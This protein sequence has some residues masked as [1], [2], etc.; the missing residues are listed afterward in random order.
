MNSLPQDST[1]RKQCSNPD[2]HKWY[3]ATTEFFHRATDRKSGLEAQCKE[4]KSKRQQAHLSQPIAR[5][6]RRAYFNR[7]DIREHTR[8]WS[9]EYYSDPKV[10]AHYLAYHK[11]NNKRPE[12]RAQML[13]YSRKPEVRKRNIAYL[14]VYRKLPEVRSRYN[15]PEHR[16]KWCVYSHIRRARK[17]SIKGTFTAAQIQEQLKRQHYR[18]YYAACGHAKFEKRNGKYIYHIDHTFPIS[19]VAGTDIPAN[20]IDYLVLACPHCNDSKGKKFPWEWPE[21]GRLL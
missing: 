13:A 12:R 11:E 15:G 21:G 10:Y 17:K 6:R 5:E 4:C 3:P 19:R 2:C 8:A 16:P 1:P 18:C 9:E 14:S 7:P 20:S